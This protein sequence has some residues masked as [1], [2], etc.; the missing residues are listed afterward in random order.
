MNIP[1]FGEIEKITDSRYSL[2][3]LV[4]GRAR[5]LVA[6]A[7]PL[8]DTETTKPVSV[9]LEE[10]LEGAVS[11]ADQ[12]EAEQIERLRLQSEYIDNEQKRLKAEAEMLLNGEE[13]Q[14]DNAK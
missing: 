8:I 13:G 2:A 5:E 14:S 1:S 3:M 11:F 12:K 4:S 9:A 10:I 7:E 6:G